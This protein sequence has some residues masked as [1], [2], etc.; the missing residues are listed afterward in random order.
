MFSDLPEKGYQR[1]LVLLLYGVL[2]AFAAVVFFRWLWKPLLPFLTGGLLALLLQK[3]LDFLDRR[4]GGKRG[5]HT[6]WAVLLVLLTAGSVMGLLFYL[7][8]RLFAEAGTLAERLVGSVGAVADRADELLWRLRV[9]LSSLPV[10]RADGSSVLFRFLDS[11]DTLFSEL[12]GNAATAL[13][14]HIP[15]WIGAAAAALPRCLLAVVVMLIAAV[16]LTLDG[17]KIGAFFS[18]HFPKK[19][20][21]VFSGLRGSLLSTFFLYGRAYLLLAG[22]TFSEL[23]AGFLILGIPYAPAAAA[24]I[25]VI[26]ILPV[27]GTGTVLLPWA[28]AELLHA[29]WFR[30]IGL[31]VIYAVITVVRQIA[32]PKIV[33]KHI[34]LHPLAALLAMYLGARLFGIAG[35]L[36]LPMAASVLW[37]YFS[38]RKMSPAQGTGATRGQV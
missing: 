19:T 16:Y 9:F 12:L 30:G 18:Q 15:A 14:S 2:A 36:L 6:M 1:V 31:L 28:A 5:F 25:A 3:P 23:Y 33:G 38:D 13:S 8:T 24:A 34:G 20:A 27:L 35:L 21:A 10:G 11:A 32:E 17:K 7:G 4:T 37:K 26:D 29:D 22:I